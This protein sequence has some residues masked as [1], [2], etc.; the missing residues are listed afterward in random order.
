VSSFQGVI[1]WSAYAAWAASFDG[2]SR[3]AMK[4]SEGVGFTDP[5]FYGYRQE[6][7]AAGI[8]RI[9][10]YHYGKPGLGNSP[11]SE[12]NWQAR[13][14]G[15]VR[16]SDVL[17]LDY[18]EDVREA[19]ADWA[20]H[21]LVQQQRNYDKHPTIYASDDYVRTRL[22]DARLASFPLTLANWQF[23]PNERPAC[24]PPWKLYRYLQ[25]TDRATVPGIP[26]DVDADIFLGGDMSNPGADPAFL[27]SYWS[28]S[29]TLLG[30]VPDFTTGIA[31]A[32][33]HDV[34]QDLWRGAPMMHE[35]VITWKGKDVAWQRFE[36]GFYTWENNV[37]FWHSNS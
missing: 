37:P 2:V 12:A 3:I 29:S 27:L 30:G 32:W 13:V 24:P 26:G 14:C 20:Y 22:Q 5:R 6:A 34:A 10:F 8:D 36:G 1:D 19:T 21:W 23:T 28:S 15:P 4:S 16:A 33:K 7:L 11:I 35:G 18:E 9:I 31:A 17:M 25:Y